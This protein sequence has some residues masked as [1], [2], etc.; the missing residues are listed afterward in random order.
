MLDAMNNLIYRLP[1]TLR[2]LIERYM[3][4]WCRIVHTEGAAQVVFGNMVN[5][6]AHMNGHPGTNS[7]HISC[8]DSAILLLETSRRL[9]GIYGSTSEKSQYEEQ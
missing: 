9:P 7:M 4:E 6:G 2:K 3:T 5:M 8:F 1:F